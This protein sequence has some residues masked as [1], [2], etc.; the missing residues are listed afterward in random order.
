MI[1]VC[2]IFFFKFI[3][4]FDISH[5]LDGKIQESNLNETK[6]IYRNYHSTPAGDKSQS[7]TCSFDMLIL[8][9]PIQV[10]MC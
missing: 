9:Y 7:L 2:K 4:N 10:Y 8:R 6:L 5:E 1:F 3:F